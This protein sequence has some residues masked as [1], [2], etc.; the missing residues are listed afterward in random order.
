[1]SKD[2]YL[3]VDVAG[4]H[5]KNPFYVASGPTTKS[6]RQLLRIEQAGWAA[7][8]IKLTIDPAP[9]I[10]R[11][12]RYALFHDR[13]AL[14]F[15]AE[16]RLAFH[17]GLKL[18][19]DAKKQL[20]DLILMANITYAGDGGP[21]GWVNMA[22]KFEEA[23]A[24]IIELN[25]CC[26]NMSYNV[27]L[28]GS[29]QACGVR[30]GASLGQQEGAVAEIVR[31]IKLA[32][33][34]P[35]FVKLTP[36]GGRIASVAREL[37]AAGADAVGGTANRLGIPPIDLE[38]PGRS[39]YHLQDE[40][41]MSCH[42]GAWL[43]PLALRDTYE[44]RRLNGPMPFI[45]AA[46]GVRTAADAA[47]MM[48][49]GADL[50]GI[51]SETLISGYGFIGSVIT[52]LKEYL[53]RHGYGS[54]RELR[55]IVVPLIKSA[56]E[57]TLHRGHAR[58]LEPRLS[59]PCKA[60]CPHHVPAQAYVRAVARGDFRRAFDLIV[61]KGPLQSVCGWVCS[62]PCEDECTR[63]VTGTPVPIRAIKRFVLEYGHRQGWAPQQKA[64][65]ARAEKIAVAGAGPAGLSA[66]WHLA[67][68]GYGVTVF[69]KEQSP[70]GMLRHALPAFRMDRAVLD[71]EIRAMEDLGIR[72]EMG[73]ALG[74]DFTVESLKRDG[75]ASV[76]IGIGAQQSA[77]PEL[78][79]MGARGVMH[80]LDLLKA[81]NG[82][83]PPCLGDTVVV[84]GGG[85]TALDAA[86]AAA[87]L[88]AKEVY[89]AYRRSRS[90]M[91]ASEEEITEAEQEGVRILYMV[92]P[93][94]IKAN[95]GIVTGVRFAT[96]TLAG[97][98]GSGR[99]KPMAV[100]GA[101]FTLPCS[102]A[103]FAVGQRPDTDAL[104]GFALDTAGMLPCHL[105][106]GETAM[107]H[108]YCGGDVSTV[109]TVITAIAAGRRAA[110]AIDTALAGANAVLLPEPE[111]PT[112]SKLDVLK[113]TGYFS[114]AAR[115]DLSTAAGQ[116]RVRDASP[117]IR[118]LT[119]QEAVSEAGRCLACGCGEGCGVCADICSEFAI[120]RKAD[121]VWE[122]DA[123]ECVACGMCFNRCPNAN[124][125]MVDDHSLVE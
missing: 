56:P 32:V 86:R 99:R 119:Q 2:L 50:I 35:L 36:E 123:A 69:E 7:A 66:A 95:D 97:I 85:H 27:E 78:P 26:P 8:S 18:V 40:I 106:T 104:R 91:N 38:N 101:Q 68:A 117:H 57:L 43:K 67:K 11:A 22:R 109:A 74:R 96:Q 31:Q 110:C 51:C 14:C 81:M 124:I 79:G 114:D 9:Y 93:V 54:A 49:C 47:E 48:L 6:V 71:G 118:T 92:S 59:A 12:P 52:D 15:T 25:M 37:Y 73:Q 19:Q 108:V 53:C 72:F 33:Q 77:C 41:S 102:T 1:M 17:E 60:A 84:I 13:N 20:T 62:H 5:F 122:I 112:V 58:I 70:G 46:G 103:V 80:A 65:A 42:S 39:P 120:T 105:A 83:G 98:D 63:G 45:T 125:G 16:K 89:L 30:T 87:R 24:D 115:I 3:P 4:I 111:G 23:G 21:A 76:F 116:D 121:D 34:I 90:E 10:N 44:I 88:G 94:S 75:F 55:D 107:P 100:D 61:T 82:N 113:R 28:S 64:R 29:A